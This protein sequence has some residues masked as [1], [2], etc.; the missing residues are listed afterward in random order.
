MLNMFAKKTFKNFLYIRY[1]PDTVPKLKAIVFVF[2]KLFFSPLLFFKPD[3]YFKILSKIASMRLN[4][5]IFTPQG[6]FFCRNFD[7]FW[8]ISPNY[9]KEFLPYFECEKNRVFIDVGAHIG[10][11][12]VLMAKKAEKVISIEP[13]SENFKILE[14]NV[15]INDLKNVILVKRACSDKIGS[16]KL[17]ISKDNTGGH[18]LNEKTK[19]YENINTS[20]LE[21]ICEENKIEPSQICLIKIDVEGHEKAVLEGSKNILMNVKNLRI[22]FESWKEI[23]ETRSFLKSFGFIVKKIGERYYLAEKYEK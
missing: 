11:Y 12:T 8:V 6:K 9:E 2:S 7:D 15:K 19:F 1:F 22:I 14:Y 21:K 10:K 18:S 23:E 17:Y 16:T 4:C 20:T 13:Y 3:T 5:V